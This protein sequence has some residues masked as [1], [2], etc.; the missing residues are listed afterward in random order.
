[1]ILPVSFGGFRIAQVSDLHNAEFGEGNENLIELLSQ[2]DPDI[3][4]LT[5]DLIDWAKAHDRNIK[6]AR[7][8]EVK[9]PYEQY[10][11]LKAMEPEIERLHAEGK[12]KEIK[13]QSYRQTLENCEKQ[14]RE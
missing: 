14:L 4:V 1:M 6:I 13:Y 10:K 5:G 12:I 9:D 11:N 7:G 8:E 3:I 2:T